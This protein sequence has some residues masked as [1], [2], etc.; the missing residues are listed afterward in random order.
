MERLTPLGAL[1]AGIGAGIVGTLTLSILARIM[2]GMKLGHQSEP[3]GGGSEEPDHGREMTAG[4]TP[5][6]ALTEPQSPGP[7]G[8]A[9]QFAFKIAAGVFGKDI[10][11]FA[12]SWALATHLAYGAAWG[13]LL[14]LIMGTFRLPEIPFGLAFGFIVWLVGPA[15]LVPAMRIL[16]PLRAQGAPRIALLVSAHLA[17]GLVVAVAF[18]FLERRFA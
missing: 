15:I 6:Q 5:A 9:Q 12:R 2:P 7:E 16:P 3:S 13:A 8:L 18:R 10:S 4:A 17:W 14:G 1:F 11:G